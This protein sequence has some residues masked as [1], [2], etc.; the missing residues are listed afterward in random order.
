MEHWAGRRS[1]W[2]AAGGGPDAEHGLGQAPPAERGQP[3]VLVDRAE[4]LPQRGDRQEQALQGEGIELIGFGEEAVVLV[5]VVVL[6]RA[7]PGPAAQPVRAVR[8]LRCCW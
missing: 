2:R 1:A 8:L 4:H 3:L 7:L 5:L 6:V